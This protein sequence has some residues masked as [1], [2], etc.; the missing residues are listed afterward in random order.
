MSAPIVQ[1]AHPGQYLQEVEIGARL[2]SGAGK[3][4]GAMPVIAERGPI[5]VP[6]VVRSPDEYR[7]IYGGPVKGYYSYDAMLGYFSEARAPLIVLRT[8]NYG[9][10]LGSYNIVYATQD[11]DNA[12]ATKI[13]S[14]SATSQGSWANGATCQFELEDTDPKA[15][16]DT[17]DTPAVGAVSYNLDNV[18]GFEIGDHI[19]IS[20]G[21]LLAAE[22][23][24]ILDVDDSTNVLTVEDTLS[25]TP[26]SAVT[27]MTMTFK[28]TVKL[29]GNVEVFDRL[30]ISETSSRYIYAILSVDN[31]GI[32][33]KSPN[34]MASLSGTIDTTTD[35]RP[36]EETITLSG[37]TDNYSSITSVDLAGTDNVGAN[38]LQDIANAKILFCV[39]QWGMVTDNNDAIYKALVQIAKN[40]RF[41]FAVG[42]ISEDA[43]RTGSG[44][45]SAYYEVQNTINYKDMFG[46]LNY[47]WIQVNLART[48][49]PGLIPCAG[50]VAGLYT[51]V[52][53]TRGIYKAPAGEAVK[54]SRVT[55]LKHSVTDEDQDQLN[56]IG[57]NCIR[58]F[59]GGGIIMWGARTQ[60]NNIKWRYI[61]TRRYQ[62]W[63]EESVMTST[64]WAAFEPNDAEL[65]GNIQEAIISFMTRLTNAGTLA[66]RIP[67]E[68]FVVRCDGTNNTNDTID[69]GR[70]IVDVGVAH[71]KPAE[72]LI[73]RFTQTRAGAQIEQIAQL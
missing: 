16:Y 66:S 69:E 48:N 21:G 38:I 46:A 57:L 29:G 2:V 23:T 51:Q 26:T 3:G 59:E 45:G 9:G 5:G 50:D 68:A 33:S 72:F 73:Y 40:K 53:E 12:L 18:D 61:P 56:P 58:S 67:A 64:R 39:D 52:D 32:A 42:D 41:G 34:V 36:K 55:N 20:D 17:S 49:R 62:S 31:Y 14:L 24:V 8:A 10:S 35:D 1:V 54:F 30:S 44:A 47:P 65:R 43:T 70:F 6:I 27:I 63:I 4:Y 7:T 37:G 28:A 13:G 71:T 11:I 60:S 15:S 25:G 19:Q 22:Y